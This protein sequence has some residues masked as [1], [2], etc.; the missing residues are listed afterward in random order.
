MPRRYRVDITRTAARDITTIYARIAHANP[1]A[2]AGWLDTVERNII[3]LAQWPRRCPIIPEA[4]E[5]EVEYRH[6]IN[7][8]YRTIF[9]I[10]SSRV[11]IVRVIHGA[12]L[13]DL[14]I[15]DR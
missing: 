14:E 13:L 11:I 5:L 4:S 9:R 7:T 10:V 12:Q 2:A 8:P 6:L 1:P 3:S 15:L